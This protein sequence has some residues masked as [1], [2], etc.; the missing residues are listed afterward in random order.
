M[1]DRA[2][3]HLPPPSMGDRAPIHLPPPSM[4][5][6]DHE[7]V[8][9]ETAAGRYTWK[10]EPLSGHLAPHVSPRGGRTIIHHLHSIFEV[11]YVSKLFCSH[12]RLL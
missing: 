2:P 8:E 12:V 4:G 9:G 1:G 7:V 3:I 5:E 6:G 11:T 10:P